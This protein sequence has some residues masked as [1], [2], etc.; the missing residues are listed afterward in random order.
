MGSLSSEHVDFHKHLRRLFRSTR[1]NV[2]PLYCDYSIINEEFK[3]SKEKPQSHG[4]QNKGGLIW[5]QRFF[6]FL[7]NLGSYIFVALSV[8][9]ENNSKRIS[10]VGDS[11]LLWWDAV[12]NMV[13][14]DC[15]GI[16]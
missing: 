13:K 8:P 3:K 5:S 12:G 11:D 7:S 14:I 15:E 1:L 6:L 16:E 2:A 9:M 10:D 4:G